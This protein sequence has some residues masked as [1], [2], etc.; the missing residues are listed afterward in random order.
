MTS[1]RGQ[2]PNAPHALKKA[3][4]GLCLVSALTLT[5]PM[6][7]GSVFGNASVQAGETLAENGPLGVTKAVGQNTSA[8]LTGASP[9]RA[10]KRLGNTQRGLLNRA[11][12]TASR[13]SKGS[14]GPKKPQAMKAYRMRAAHRVSRV[15]GSGA[16]PGG[17]SDRDA[18]MRGLGGHEFLRLAGRLSGQSCE[19]IEG[20]VI[21]RRG[22]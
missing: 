15:P 19:T 17:F 5:P 14:A 9:L 4:L 6:W 12:N 18:M 21:V 7:P 22:C 11:A 3:A 13:G 8:V 20:G 10:I 1:I 2:I 16:R